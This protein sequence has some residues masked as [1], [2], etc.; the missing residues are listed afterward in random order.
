MVDDILDELKKKYPRVTK[1]TAYEIETDEK[2]GDTPYE[3][4]IKF[5]FPEGEK[6]GY[7]SIDQSIGIDISE[8]DYYRRSTLLKNLNNSPMSDSCSFSSI[9]EGFDEVLDVI[10]RSK[11]KIG[12]DP[13]SVVRAIERAR[14][15]LF[16]DGIGYY[17]NNKDD[18]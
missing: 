15:D 1:E 17:E 5:S 6:F 4:E 7:V 16:D 14:M 8:S 9:E 10:C 3:E 2:F 18:L 12:A 13:S 11:T